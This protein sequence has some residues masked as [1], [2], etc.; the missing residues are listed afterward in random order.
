MKA[1]ARAVYFETH[2]T[3]ITELKASL[4]AIWK[5]KIASHFDLSGK[6]RFLRLS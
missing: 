6:E 5:G 2:A 1:G 4:S 3:E